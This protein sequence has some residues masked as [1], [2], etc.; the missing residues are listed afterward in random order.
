MVIE[1]SEPRN[2]FKLVE[3][4]PMTVFFAGGIGVTPLWSMAQRLQALQRPWRLYYRGR[5]RATTALLRE[6]ATPEICDSVRLSFSDDP[7]GQRIDIAQVVADSPS[8]T[9]FYCC[10]PLSMLESF[11]AGCASLA[12][13]FVH[14]EYFQA[15]DAPATEGG[16]VVRLA[17]TGK[18]IPIEPGRTVLEALAEAG[19]S[20]PSSCQQGVCGACE[21]KV[22]AGCPD[23]RDLVLSEAER[24]SGTTMMICCSGSHTPELVLDL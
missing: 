21:T 20:V 9:H 10:G 22:L 12:E 2:D 14:A 5:S 18:A 15:K 4:A 13:E 3:D 23:H 6:L 17:R 16:F 8:G 11:E 1:I 19:V 7:S 24:K